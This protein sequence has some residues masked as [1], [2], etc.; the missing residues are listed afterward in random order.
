MA[1][2]ARPNWSAAEEKVD[3]L[4]SRIDDDPIMRGRISRVFAVVL[5]PVRHLPSRT[6]D[7][8]EWR[9]QRRASKKRTQ[10][11]ATITR[12]QEFDWSK[13]WD[14]GDLA[15][16]RISELSYISTAGLSA[17]ANLESMGNHT[18]AAGKGL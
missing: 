10:L 13:L 3:E 14:Y 1:L 4:E 17:L 15:T 16:G 6:F 2:L 8:W 9:K 7:D 11:A 18:V 12:V 5:E